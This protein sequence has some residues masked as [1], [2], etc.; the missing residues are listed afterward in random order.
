MEEKQLT[1]KSIDKL[2]KAPEINAL[3]QFL[4]EPGFEAQKKLAIALRDDWA[5]QITR[6]DY[7]VIQ[8]ERIVKD[9]IFKQGMLHGIDLFMGYLQKKHDTW[10]KEAEKEREH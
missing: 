8:D 10:R 2:L 3:K 1:D 4:A 6:I 5:D 9:M 7:R